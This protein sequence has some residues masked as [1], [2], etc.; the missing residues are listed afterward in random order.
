MEANKNKKKSLAMKTFIFIIALAVLVTA[1]I[2][3][4]YPK[5][6]IKQ[7]QLNT[8]ILLSKTQISLLEPYANKISELAD[9]QAEYIKLYN[10]DTSLAAPV[11]F[12]DLI[13]SAAKKSHFAV[14]SLSIDEGAE[15]ATENKF[16]AKVYV[17]NIVLEMQEGFSAPE[18]IKDLEASKGTGIYVNNVEYSYP[19]EAKEGLAV[20]T[21]NMYTM[22]K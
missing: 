22:E 16:T 4:V 5:I 18:F 6:S 19:E 15:I 12:S 8:D 11:M 17:A 3:A 1:Y 13:Y 7:S 9:K 2:V 21:V 20:I 10:E 14:R